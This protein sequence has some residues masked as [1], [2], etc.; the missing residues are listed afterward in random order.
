MGVQDRGSRVEMYS[1]VVSGP[2]LVGV[3][4]ARS[5][6]YEHADHV[7]QIVDDLLGRGN[8]IATGGAM[9]TDEYV[10]CRLLR[11]GRSDHCTVFAAWKGFEGFPA[12]VRAAI[13][14]FKDY[15]GN[16]LWG[17]AAK[18]EPLVKTALLMR[19]LRLVDASYGLV[20]F[21]TGDSRGTIFTIKKAAAKRK[22]IVVFPVNCEFP[23][24]TG[25]KWQLLRCGG[26]WEGAA[27]AVYL[28]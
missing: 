1:R 25:V 22:P 24:I 4:G 28:R 5:L 10:L 15:G 27:K 9:G 20:A 12:K 16:I 14:Q 2:R 19:N 11:I 13:R 26:I 3:V 8:H 17:P 6:S 18:T 7:G 21:I 23:E